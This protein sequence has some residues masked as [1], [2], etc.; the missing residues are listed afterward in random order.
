MEGRS[1][2]KKATVALAV[3]VVGV[4]AALVV[5]DSAGAG[6]HSKSTSATT[7]STAAAV[8]GPT[9][10]EVPTATTALPTTATTSLP[11]T[12]VTPPTPATTTYTPPL[13]E[14]VVVT[15]TNPEDLYLAL[16]Q[17][18]QQLMGMD[19]TDQANVNAFIAW[20]HSQET[21][22]QA[23]QSNIKP[24]TPEAAAYLWISKYFPKQISEN[25][26]LNGFNAVTCMIQSGHPGPCP[27]TTTTWP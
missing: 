7:G 6:R 21:A 15:L 12:T 23:G 18:A 8:V 25:R 19:D 9:T 27:V 13:T 20:Y 10:T 26:F 1:M 14:P 16:Q 3:A 24:P 17:T 11:P 2:L 22:F 5:V 4:G